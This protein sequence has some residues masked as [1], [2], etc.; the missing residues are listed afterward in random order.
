M[1]YVLLCRSL[2]SYVVMCFFIYVCCSVVLYVV[3]CVIV[4]VLS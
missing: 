1:V 2:V 4:G 3:M